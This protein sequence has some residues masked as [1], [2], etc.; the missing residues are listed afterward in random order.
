MKI[1]FDYNE[2]SP[3]VVKDVLDYF[4]EEYGSEHL[5]FGSINM[6]ITVRRKEDNASIGWYDNETGKEKELYIK[7]KP[8]KKT[9]KS[10]LNTII[11]HT[12]SD[13]GEVEENIKAYI[14]LK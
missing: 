9:K 5:Q 7:S 12:E 10:L 4:Y 13:T 2:V 3:D 11:E 1:H 8:M 14:Y 6:Y